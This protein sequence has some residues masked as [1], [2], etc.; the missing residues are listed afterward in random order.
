MSDSMSPLRWAVKES[1][2]DY[3]RGLEDGTIETFDGCESVDGAFVF[4]G[5]SAADGGLLFTGGVRFTGF[6][7]MLDVRLVDPMIEGD[8]PDKTLSALVGV[9]SIAAR[10][11][12]ATIEGAKPRHAGH[13]W[14]ATPRITFE[15][16]RIFGDVYQTG[17]DLAPLV[18]DREQ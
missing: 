4:P 6:S 2:I 12:I 5:V 17:T 14:A 3:I 8:G 10:V 13:R 7:G 15:G 18:V 9:P 1:F 11:A 16:V